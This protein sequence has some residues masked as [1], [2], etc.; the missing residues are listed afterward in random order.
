MIVTSLPAIK[1]A[2][3]IHNKEGSL[4]SKPTH[5]PKIPFNNSTLVTTLSQL[6]STFISSF[7]ASFLLC[8]FQ[9]SF[10]CVLSEFYSRS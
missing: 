1:Y 6:G 2:I 4:P 7:R 3:P 5:I 10:I 9:N 8:N